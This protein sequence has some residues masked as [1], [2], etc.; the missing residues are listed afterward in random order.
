MK[1]PYF[2]T[3]IFA[4]IM[5]VGFSIP[6][7]P[8]ADIADLNNILAY[9]LSDKL[10]HAIIFG[11]FVWLWSVGAYKEGQ[12]PIP[13][14]TLFLGAWGYG[15]FIELWQYLLPYRSFEGI[16][17]VFDLLGI[18]MGLFIFRIVKARKWF[19]FRKT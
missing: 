19:L 17:L 1:N 8:I 2:W 18:V 6:G 5:L 11:V 13:Y 7:K 9:L 4:I 16:D 10:L 12:E 14:L 15:L 3:R